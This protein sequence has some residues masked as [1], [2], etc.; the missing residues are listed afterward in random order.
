M[1]IIIHKHSILKEVYLEPK[2]QN[3]IFVLMIN[4]FEINHIKYNFNHVFFFLDLENKYCKIQTDYIYVNLNNVVYIHCITLL[5]EY[6]N[7]KWKFLCNTIF[8]FSSSMRN[9]NDLI[10]TINKKRK[11][12]DIIIKPL[13]LVK[14]NNR[15]FIY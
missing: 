5:C 10:N 11:K 9:T 3:I 15:L 6:F 4:S 13:E 1:K 8:Q 14:L 2:K 7:F 12:K